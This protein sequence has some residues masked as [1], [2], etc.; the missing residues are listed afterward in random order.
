MFLAL[1]RFHA[2]LG[3][4][5]I[6]ADV[7][8]NPFSVEEPSLIALVYKGLVCR[9][10]CYDALLLVLLRFHACHSDDHLTLALCSILRYHAVVRG[11]IN[12]SVKG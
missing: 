1:G 3:V 2:T 9:C 8:K 5:Q 4:T 11:S 12:Y 10:I 6:L 7:L